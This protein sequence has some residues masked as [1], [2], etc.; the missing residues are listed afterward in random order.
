MIGKSAR[1][2]AANAEGSV[3]AMRAGTTVDRSIKDAVKRSVDGT[4]RRALAARRKRLASAIWNAVSCDLSN[5]VITNDQKG[6][7]SVLRVLKEEG[8]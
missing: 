2:I 4:A 6:V 7:A 3:L 1:K 8:Y 5:G